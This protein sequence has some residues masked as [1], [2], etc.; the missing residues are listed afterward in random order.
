VS[1][2]VNNLTQDDNSCMMPDYDGG[3]LNIK[4]RVDNTALYLDY[5]LSNERDDYK[6][7][8]VGKRFVGFQVKGFIGISSGNPQQQNVNDIDVHKITF[9][10]MNPDYY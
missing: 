10:N 7:C 9:Y 5:S 3:N 1:A 8:I 2:A 4:Y 6:S